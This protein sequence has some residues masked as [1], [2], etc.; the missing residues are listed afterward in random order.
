MSEIDHRLDDHERRIGSLE[1]D[2][3]ELRAHQARLERSIG[4]IE[5]KLEQTATKADLASATGDI[6]AKLHHSIDGVL[7]AALNTVPQK[8]VS[9]WTILTG[10]FGFG[11]LIIA[12]IEARGH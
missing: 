7:M 1:D 2:Q 10:L 9:I 5:V 12:I 6:I 4:E 3:K 8:Q 11:G